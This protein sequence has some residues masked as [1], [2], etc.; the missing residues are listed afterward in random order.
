MSEILAKLHNLSYEIFAIM[1]P[2]FVGLLFAALWGT[3][4][5]DLVP[6]WSAS[7]VPPLTLP[8]LHQGIKLL[9]GD[10]QIGLGIPCVVIAYLVGH[11]LHWIGRRP[12][13]K[14]EAKGPVAAAS[15]EPKAW[16]VNAGN[17][18]CAL[19]FRLPKAA[20]SYSASLQPVVDLL[21]ERFAAPSLAPLQ[22]GTLF[23]VARVYVQQRLPS[24]LI[25]MYQHKYTFHRSVAI[26][27]VFLVWGSTFGLAASLAAGHALPAVGAN[28]LALLAGIFGGLVLVWAFAESYKYYWQLFG[29]AVVNETYSLL[30]EPN[31]AEPRSKSAGSGP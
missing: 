7:A 21:A 12:P 19:R 2:G 28:R 13:K 15:T 14:K 22:W 4:M 16:K 20:G 1:L 29:S 18:W 5:G 27:S 24:S 6:F 17:L 10:D 3:A 30:Y 31:H 25:S 8:T 26:S 23:P 11:C 9:A